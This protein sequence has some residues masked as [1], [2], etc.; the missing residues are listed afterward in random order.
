M[1]EL[2]DDLFSD[3]KKEKEVSNIYIKKNE[4]N[5]IIDIEEKDINKNIYFLDNTDYIDEETKITHFHDNLTELNPSNVELYINNEKY[6]Y[7]KYFIPKKEGI[8]SIKLIFKINIKNCSYMFNECNN[9]LNIDLSC[10]NTKNVLDMSYMFA[11]C[12]KLKSINLVNF[13]TKNVLD[14]SYMFAYCH[15]L[16]NINIS[17]FN[18][19]NVTNMNSLFAYCYILKDLNLSSFDTSKVTDMGYMFSNCESLESLDLSFFNTEKVIDMCYMFSSCYKLKYIDLSSFNI[20]NVANVNGIFFPC[21]NLSK[22][23]IN[24]DFYKLVKYQID[25]NIE[26]ILYK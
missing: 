1:D 7:Q 4:I 13:D 24:K 16:S 11:Y 21:S 3:I 18:T 10:F 25:S 15:N 23:K 12:Y 6:Q 9:L 20:K 22:I 8:Y 5:I 26:I 2:K 19:K 17:F 14:M